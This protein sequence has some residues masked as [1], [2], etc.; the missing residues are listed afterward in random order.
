[1]NNY[2]D[3]FKVIEK[4]KVKT[5]ELLFLNDIVLLNL[6]FELFN[7]KQISIKKVLLNLI[8]SPLN[9]ATI[10][11][12]IFLLL[13]IKLPNILDTTLVNLANLAPTL[14]LLILGGTLK[15][16]EFNNFSKTELRC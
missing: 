4:Q 1:M 15:L 11:G 8:S 9:I 14:A 2:T 13:N 5:N 7:K 6:N 3:N 10:L 16:K 12:F